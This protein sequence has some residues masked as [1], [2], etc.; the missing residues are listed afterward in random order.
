MNPE[1]LPGSLR[2]LVEGELA[3]GEVI[4][5]LAQL[6]PECKFLR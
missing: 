1:V 3:Q 2:R 6:F 4:R 5:W